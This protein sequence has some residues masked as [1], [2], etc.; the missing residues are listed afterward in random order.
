MFINISKFEDTFIDCIHN[1]NT[2]ITIAIILYY[3]YYFNN[4]LRY[5]VYLIMPRILNYGFE[6]GWD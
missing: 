6:Q 4:I 5:S 1:I 3:F 2:Y